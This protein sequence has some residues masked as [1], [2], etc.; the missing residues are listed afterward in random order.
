LFLNKKPISL[1]AENEPLRNIN[2]KNAK[3][4]MIYKKKKR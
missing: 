1:P 2:G 3:K 4:G